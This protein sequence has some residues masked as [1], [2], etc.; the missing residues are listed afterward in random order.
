MTSVFDF[1]NCMDMM[2]QMLAQ[3][4]MKARRR[5]ALAAQFEAAEEEEEEEETVRAS[6]SV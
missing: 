1:D 2:E 5:A 3:T 4:V 6:A